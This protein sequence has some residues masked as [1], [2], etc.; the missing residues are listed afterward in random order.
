VAQKAP[1]ELAGFRAFLVEIAAVV[2]D[3]NTEGGFVGMGAR[4][5][6]PHEADAM[7]AVRKAA[8]LKGSDLH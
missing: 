7:E 3:A 5:R 1:Q 8:D 4:R 6:T 2:A